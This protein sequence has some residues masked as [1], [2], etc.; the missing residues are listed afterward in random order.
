M[1]VQEVMFPR[2]LLIDHEVQ[3]LTRAFRVWF[4]EALRLLVTH[5]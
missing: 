3:E 2:P 5:H 4:C 1:K